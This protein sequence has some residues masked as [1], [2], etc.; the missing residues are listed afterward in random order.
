MNLNFT[1]QQEQFEQRWC[2]SHDHEFVFEILKRFPEANKGNNNNKRNK[3]Q[4]MIVWRTSISHYG[5]YRGP[6]G[7]SKRFLGFQGHLKELNP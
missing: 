2:F 7:G 3:L 6:W 5:V 1:P 4:I